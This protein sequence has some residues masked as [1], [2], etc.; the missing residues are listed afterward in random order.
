M[1][2]TVNAW[3]SAT[4]IARAE[5]RRSA[6]VP[7]PKSIAARLGLSLTV[8]TFGSTVESPRSMPTSRVSPYLGNRGSDL[9]S[10]GCFRLSGDRGR[11]PLRRNQVGNASLVLDGFDP[12]RFASLQQALGDVRMRQLLVAARADVASS[13]AQI[14]ECAA[15]HDVVALGAAAHALCGAAGNIGASQIQD[16]AA[17][18]RACARDG[19]DASTL[20]SELETAVG[21]FEANINHLA[22]PDP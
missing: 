6:K 19:A 7:P 2:R 18:L 21:V 12:V 4:A 10:A 13:L 11:W 20:L 3:T 22:P 5:V 15:R 9:C 16:R 17:R 14:R 8:R 1:K